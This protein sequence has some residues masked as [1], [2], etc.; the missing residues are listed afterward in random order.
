MLLIQDFWSILGHITYLAFGRFDFIVNIHNIKLIP[1]A[2]GT[3]KQL[4]ADWTPEICKICTL[5]G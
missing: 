1:V 3:T 2:I 4:V 5:Y